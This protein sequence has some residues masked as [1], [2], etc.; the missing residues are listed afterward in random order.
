MSET[1]KI[2]CGLVPTSSSNPASAPSA[3]KPCPQSNRPRDPYQASRMSTFLFLLTLVLTS[4]HLL[5]TLLKFY[6]HI[7]KITT[8]TVG[9]AVV[10]LTF[11]RLIQFS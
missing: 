1:L 8:Q 6:W 2:F 5:S 4:L 11:V 10:E 3:H 7:T 9:E